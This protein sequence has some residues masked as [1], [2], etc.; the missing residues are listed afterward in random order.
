VTAI[1]SGCSFFSPLFI[2]SDTDHPV[3]QAKGDILKFA[4]IPKLQILE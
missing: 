4:A 3:P 1:G 2:P